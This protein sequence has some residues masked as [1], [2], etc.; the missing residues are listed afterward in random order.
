MDCKA[1]VARLLLPVHGVRFVMPFA[2]EDKDVDSC[3][4]SSAVSGEAI[5]EAKFVER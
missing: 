1:L 2:S 3:L 5:H 4:G